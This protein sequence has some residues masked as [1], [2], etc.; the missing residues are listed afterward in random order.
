[1]RR[2]ALF[3]MGAFVVMLLSACVI[4]TAQKMALQDT[5]VG[6][7]TESPH[8]DEKDLHPDSAPL[9]F[10]KS[11]PKGFRKTTIKEC[12]LG[13]G[14]YLAHKN[15]LPEDMIDCILPYESQKLGGRMLYLAPRLILG[16]V[17]D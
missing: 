2:Y 16:S 13:G 15:A 12:E 8:S 9:H 4:Q 10:V 3:V 7:E 14:E 6:K 17:Y 5:D 11:N 1:M